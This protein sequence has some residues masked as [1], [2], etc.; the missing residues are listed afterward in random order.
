M[1][2][3]RRMETSEKEIEKGGCLCGAVRYE[4]DR[5]SILA[6]CN[7]HCRDCQRQ[8]GSGYTTFVV[9]AEDG[10]KLVSGNLKSCTRSPESDSLACGSP[11]NIRSFC[12]ECG[13]PI[14]G[15]A[16]S[17]PGLVFVKAGSLDESD[18]IEITSSYW[19]RTARKWALPDQSHLVCAGD[20]E[21]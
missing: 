15:S 19:A 3:E 6:A 16:L 7:C 11:A 13:S 2:L 9:V 21:S 12:P 20:P 18:W 8:T 14:V 4:L 1:I 5:S 17:G 10:F